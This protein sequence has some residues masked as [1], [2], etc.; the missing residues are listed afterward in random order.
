[1][2]RYAQDDGSSHSLGPETTPGPAP[3]PA[4][5]RVGRTQGPRGPNVAARP[6][7]P[8]G[9][10]GAADRAAL[11]RDRARPGRGFLGRC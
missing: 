2:E 1:M 8:E 6:G 4:R 11:W 3:L 7:G 9:F 10:L 5:A